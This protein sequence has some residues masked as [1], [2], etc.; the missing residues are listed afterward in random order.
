MAFAHWPLG[1]LFLRYKLWLVSSKAYQHQT[2]I[3]THPIIFKITQTS[4]FLTILP[5][6]HTP[7]EPHLTMIRQGLIVSRPQAA[8]ALRSPLQWTTAA[9]P[10]HDPLQCPSPRSP[11]PSLLSEWR[12]THCKPLPSLRRLFQEQSNKT[13]VLLPPLMVVPFHLTSPQTLRPPTSH[14]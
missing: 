8:R 14:L 2:Q 4:R 9:P 10:R 5:A 11:Q 12:S 7:M 6:L 3:F 13:Y 1:S